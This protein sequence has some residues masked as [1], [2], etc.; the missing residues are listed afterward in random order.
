LS[1][2]FEPTTADSQPT[3]VQYV[4]RLTLWN[5]QSLWQR[6]FD[7]YCESN[8]QPAEGD[9]EKGTVM[10]SVIGLF[11][12]KDDKKKIYSPEI[13]H[14]S[15]HDV[16]NLMLQMEFPFELISGSLLRLA[17]GAGIAK[18]YAINSLK[19]SQD[20]L[21]QEYLRNLSQR[22]QS[23]LKKGGSSILD[24]TNANP[25]LPRGKWLSKS[26][27]SDKGAVLIESALRYL[28][29]REVYMVSRSCKTLWKDG[30][31]LARRAALMTD[32]T[33][34]A[35]IR[36]QLWKSFIDPALLNHLLKDY[37]GKMQDDDDHVIVLDV[38]RTYSD[39]ADF[40]KEVSLH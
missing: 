13:L 3:L 12:K 24:T 19:N 37:K 22:F 5:D 16:E 8:N 31:I 40:S 20:Y 36:E 28:L 2:V 1:F 27:L 39:F 23:K 30:S 10:Q 29:P 11:S 33:L 9:P 15:F 32:Q 14:K 35:E 25:S 4:M 26:A 18:E 7:Y 17:K 38:K 6:I 34:S 21:V